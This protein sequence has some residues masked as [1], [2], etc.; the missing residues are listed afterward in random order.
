M[1]TEVGLV[2]DMW[3]PLT[4]QAQIAP[5]GFDGNP[6]ML[7]R[8]DFFWMAVVGRVKSGVSLKQAESQVASLYQQHVPEEDRLG[9]YKKAIQLLPV[10]G[11]M[12]PRERGDFLPAAGLLFAVVGM[13]LLI[14]CVN[15]ANLLL[16]R[17]SSRY[18]EIGIRFA[19]GASRARVIR[20]LLAESVLLS[21]AGG[22]CGFLF[23]LWL[24]DISALFAPVFGQPFDLGIHTD[25]RV[26]AATLVISLMTGILFGILPAL[27][28]SRREVT[29]ALK[30]GSEMRLGE[31][32][33]RLRST[34]VV[35]QL[36]LSLV[37]LISAGLFVRSLSRAT[38]LDLGFRTDNSLMLS[39]N[40][41]QVGLSEA[42]GRNFLPQLM[43]TLET[44]P[45]VTSASAVR[46]SPLGLES[47]GT[48]MRIEGRPESSTKN[49]E[50]FP[51][52]LAGPRYFE[53]MGIPI[54]R[55]RDFTARDNAAG[56]PVVI[57]NDAAAQRFWPGEDPLGRRVSLHQGVWSEVVGVVRNSVL[58]DLSEKASP[59]FYQ[60]VLQE[61]AASFH[62]VVRTTGDPLPLIPI[63]RE[64]LHR[65]N[66]D[67]MVNQ[68]R[69][70]SDQIS[71]SLLPRRIGAMVLA[72]AGC[73][74]LS[75]AVIG[76][77]GVLS[78]AIALRTREIGVR[79][80]LGAAPRDVLRL[81]IGEGM[82][83]SSW[84]IGLGIVLSLAVTRLLAGFLFAVSPTD[85]FTFV[86]VS[87][88]LAGAALLACYLPAR[89]ASRVDPMV[90]LRYE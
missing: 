40:L 38:S 37:M 21:L 84:G 75:L 27:R 6:D 56:P 9:P 73:V 62:L 76:I 86:G 19:L 52:N 32:R 47:G 64:S 5:A 63:I 55:G 2:R 77:Y 51:F 83:M 42:Q 50:Y 1:G 53:T 22:V 54:L 68:I 78:F 60:P 72:A 13:V 41:D 82:R 14:A 71:N 8:A 15:L 65:L 44:A 61:Y 17:A 20:Q 90:A 34:L 33:S 24:S 23:S 26:L 87:A 70:T 46:F 36:S 29:S 57:I 79:M 81:V 30:G 74:A 85:A 89:R 31:R 3:I 45:G 25:A 4:M 7:A 66:G 39:V 35:A 88:L 12:D 48:S 11:S 67:L 18:K 59:T 69:T 16:A 10:T 28:V 43:E 58:R 80:A 49:R